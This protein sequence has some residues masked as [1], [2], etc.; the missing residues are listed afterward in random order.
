MNLLKFITPLN[1][2]T[3]KEKFFTNDSYN[4]IFRYYWQEEEPMYTTYG[5]KLDM[6]KAIFDQNVSNIHK[7]AS[8]QFEI[9]SW[10]HIDLAEGILKT[11]PV[12]LIIED[13]DQIV[14]KFN[15]AFNFLGLTDYKL[16]IVDTHGFNFRPLCHKR[17]LQM[18]KYAN[19]EYMSVDGEI[20]HELVHIIR[21]EN[22]IYNKIPRSDHY[23]PTEEGLATF[24]QDKDDI[25]GAS[26]YQHAAEYMASRV[27]LSGSL[28]DIYN[29]FIGLGFSEDLAWQRA[30]RHKFGFVDTKEP[31]DILKP[32]MYFAN[33]QRVKTLS[34]KYLLSLFRGKI[35]LDDFKSKEVYSGII[36][37]DRLK[38]FFKLNE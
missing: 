7:Y 11:K 2:Q 16:S 6:M 8:K 10:E 19:F 4:P 25:E 23:L 13:H 37:K 3:E 14:E 32:A 15:K 17:V 20:R 38:K 1:L 12:K 22:G 24:M 5:N 28:R 9:G 30:S 33:A 31:G 34:D 21:Y 18:S 29:H 27:G 35:S 26:Q 36:E